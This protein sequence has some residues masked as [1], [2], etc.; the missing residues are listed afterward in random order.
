M[1]FPEQTIG[2]ELFSSSLMCTVLLPQ[3]FQ[4][5]VQNGDQGIKFGLLRTT[6]ALAV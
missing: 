6:L 2:C 1:L 3:L 5:N 4:L